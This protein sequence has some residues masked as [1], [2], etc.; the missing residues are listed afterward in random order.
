MRLGID[1]GSTRIVVSVAD[2]GNYPVVQFEAPDGSTRDWFP[3]LVAA[4]GSERRY[5]WDAWSLQADPDWTVIRSLKR[6]LPECG[7]ATEVELGGTVVPL[8]TLLGELTAN[9]R[10][11][12]LEG[13]NAPGLRAGKNGP[14][15][16]QLGV[17]ANANTNQRFLTAEAFRWGGFET[18]GLLNEPSAASLEYSHQNPVD[19]DR[20]RVLLVYDLGGGTFDASLV[21]VVGRSHSVLGSEGLSALGGDD[22]DDIL[23]ELALNEAGVPEEAREAMTQSEWFRLREECRARKEAI[24]PNT[25]KIPVDL[26]LARDEW[27]E[28]SVPVKEFYEKCRPAIDETL[29]AVSDLLGRFGFQPDGSREDG[30]RLEAVYVAGGGSELPL[31]PRALREIFGRRVKRSAYGRSSTAIGLAIQADAAAGYVLRDRFTRYFGVWR[32]A[33]GGAQIS[34]DPL[35]AKETELPAAGEAPLAI[36]RRYRPAHNIGHFRFLECSRLGDDGQPAG[37]ITLWDDFRFPF[38]PALAGE[39]N[40]EAVH[41]GRSDSAPWQEIEE[42]YRCDS[43]GRLEVEV[44][45]HSSSYGRT[46]RLGRWAASDKQVKP[47]RRRRRART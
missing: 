23:A 28:T 47:G 5:G 30:A 13:S 27:S 22:F 38:D 21:S 18:L 41:V 4:R 37:D 42:A 10:A 45:N 36:E 15:E 11:A 40:L 14:L 16:A 26:G 8:Q 32:E 39:A 9:L 6:L 35:F 2:R 20:E 46:F 33:E 12:L 44:R 1:F 29:H 25:R 31:A 17:P 19:H 3:P 43:S 7:P 34:F 24:Q